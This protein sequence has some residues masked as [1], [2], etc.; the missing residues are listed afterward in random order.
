MN[1]D[2]SKSV[3]CANVRTLGNAQSHITPDDRTSSRTSSAQSSLKALAGAVLGRTLPRT[4]SAQSAQNART[5]PAHSEGAPHIA[6]EAELTR[7]VRLCG[8]RYHFTESEH[9]EALQVALA[10]AGAALT[11]F[12][13]IA[14]EIQPE[15]EPC[16]ER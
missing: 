13:A 3:Q 7:L 1:P 9:A 5:L 2:C 8:D 15:G 11:C 14:R 12:R 10:D 6:P 4:S 16:H